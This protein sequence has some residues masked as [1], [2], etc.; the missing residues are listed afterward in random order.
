MKELFPVVVSKVLNGEKVTIS[1]EV[2]SL[3]ERARWRFYAWRKCLSGS[4]AADAMQVEV[5]VK[6]DS[7]SGTTVTFSRSKADPVQEI[8]REALR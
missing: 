8:L 6:E 1:F 2:R 3:A 7:S 4:E 5:V